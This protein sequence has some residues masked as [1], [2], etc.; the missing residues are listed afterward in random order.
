[1][2]VIYSVE[3][4]LNAFA[5]AVLVA[6]IVKS[7]YP[8]I[9]DLHNY[10]AANGMAQKVYNWETLNSMYLITKLYI[11]LFTPAKTAFLY[12]IHGFIYAHVHILYPFFFA[13]RVGILVH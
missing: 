3:L 8:K 1:M 2:D 5:S 13:A 7:Y 10:S 6:E 12:P 11:L 4:T 9:V